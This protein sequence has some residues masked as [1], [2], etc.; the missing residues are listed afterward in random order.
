MCADDRRLDLNEFKFG[1]A[2]LGEVMSHEDA[3]SAFREMDVDH[4]GFVLF[5]EFCSW[6]AARQLGPKALTAKQLRA[7]MRAAIKH[8]EDTFNHT[9]ADTHRVFD[10][11]DL[12]GSGDLDKREFRTACASLG[13][14]TSRAQTQGLDESHIDELWVRSTPLHSKQRQ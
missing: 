11:V 1:C 12:N 14:I 5:E 9:E 10:L 4:G 2:L 3:E 13:L 6:I 8:K 7:A